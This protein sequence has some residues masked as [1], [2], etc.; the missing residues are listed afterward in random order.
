MADG[1]GGGPAA[2]LRGRPRDLAEED[3][4]SGGSYG[5][6]G[7]ES[8]PVELADVVEDFGLRWV[9]VWLMLLIW[10][11]QACAGAVISPVPYVMDAV[12]KEYGVGRGEAA[13]LSSGVLLG[14]MLGL[15]VWGPLHDRIGRWKCILLEVGC[16]LV[17]SAAHMWLPVGVP[18]SGEEGKVSAATL[19]AWHHSFAL[20]LALRVCVGF[21]FGAIA[22]MSPMY[23][24][25][26]LASEGRGILFSIAGVGWTFGS[27]WSIFLAKY[28]EGDWRT[29]LSA[30][31]LPCLVAFIALQ[32]FPESPRWLYVSGKPEEGRAALNWVLKSPV[33]LS[34]WGQTGRY[35]EAPALVTV[36]SCEDDDDMV[37]GGGRRHV[38][39]VR[40]GFASPAPRRHRGIGAR[41][42][43]KSRQ[44]GEPVSFTERFF[45]LFSTGKDKN[46]DNLLRVTLCC[47]GTMMMI[48]GAAYGAM[49][50]AP[51]MLRELLGVDRVPYAIF[52][53]GEVAGV[54]GVFIAAALLDTRLGRRGTLAASFFMA[55]A[56]LVLLA[57]VGGNYIMILILFNLVQIS[58]GAV[59]TAQGTYTTEAFPTYLRGTANAVISICGRVV[60]MSLPIGIGEILDGPGLAAPGS[61]SSSLGGGSGGFS[62][63]PYTLAIYVLASFLVVGG[64]IALAIRRDTAHAKLS[65]V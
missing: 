10:S 5:A 63:P 49:I 25:E 43:S 54:C 22:A 36:S 20:L 35:A 37:G 44:E 55:A 11:V 58:M 39:P 24:V 33:L 61:G 16:L 27:V 21:F 40:P 13:L 29:I 65:D 2:P 4:S 7:D 41:D 3:G 14:G 52:V 1:G 50:W 51:T 57:H 38:E 46:G 17:F 31:C 6:T 8:T 64:F 45:A 9:H 19:F 30:P 56:V 53:W 48:A 15:P 32:F 28:L 60:A 12:V 62:I 18:P 59:W 23:F 47:I 26:F 42:A 34:S